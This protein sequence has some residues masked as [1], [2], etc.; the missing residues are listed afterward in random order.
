MTQVH[1]KQSYDPKARAVAQAVY[2]AIQPLA[3]I[4]FGS[5]A[6]G[7]YR[8]DSDVDLLVIT[9]DEADDRATY[10]AAR[11][12][13]H[14]KLDELYD[15]RVGVDVLDFTKSRFAY[16]CRARNH[17][18]GQALRDGVIVSQESFDPVGRDEEPTNWPDIEQRFIAATRNIITLTNLI[19]TNSPQEDIGFH[20]QQAVENALK[21]WVSALDDE[22]RN[23]HDLGDLAAI[24]RR[25]P[26][27]NDT[28]AGESLLW[29]TTYAVTYR[30]EGARVAMDDHHGLL[31]RV[32]ELVNAISNRIRALTGA[33]P[34]E[35]KPL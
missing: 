3:V 1:A 16:C 9:D 8:D 27:E 11:A 19:E 28:P 14:R 31:A 21:A 10:A 35:W 18:A 13:A 25:R 20:A 4:L 34:P 6:R 26:E 5:R 23:I 32:T 12:V 17:V 15:L 7:D 29:L 24:I 33:S 2:D 30:Y 22:Y